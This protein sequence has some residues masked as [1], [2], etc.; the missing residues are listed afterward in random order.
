MV[1]T[2]PLF[3]GVL[4]HPLLVDALMGAFRIRFQNSNT[5]RISSGHITSTHGMRACRDASLH[6]GPDMYVFVVMGCD[7]ILDT[8]SPR[9]DL[10]GHSAYCCCRCCCC[11][12]SVNDLAKKAQGAWAAT[13]RNQGCVCRRRAR[14]REAER[15]DRCRRC[16][17]FF[18]D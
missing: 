3:S 2:N 5:E 4:L 9:L 13:E 18:S 12:R 14:E 16:R 8:S 7:L 15:D 11:A 6:R 1:G 10:V 17:T